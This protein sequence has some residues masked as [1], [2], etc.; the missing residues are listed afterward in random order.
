V[1]AA[2][3]LGASSPVS[4][5]L[6]DESGGLWVATQDGLWWRGEGPGRPLL[7]AS[8]GLG[9]A[10][11]RVHRLARAGE[12]LAVATDAGVFVAWHGVGWQRVSAAG[13]PVKVLALEC[14]PG[15]CGLWWFDGGRLWRAA[16][17]LRGVERG[18][19][20]LRVDEVVQ[21]AILGAPTAGSPVDLVLGSPLGDVIAVYGRALAV[22]SWR[23]VSAASRSGGSPSPTPS[24]GQAPEAVW[25]GWTIW[26]P[27]MPPGAMSRRLFFTLGE[28]WL[29]TDRGLLRAVDPRAGWA[30]AAPPAGSS[31]IA[32]LAQG[33]SEVWAATGR[34][35][36][37]GSTAA[38]P[39]ER[40]GDA[41]EV[42]VSRR[43]RAPGAPV[44]PTIQELHRLALQHLG[45]DPRRARD[46]RRRAAQRSW[47]P[48]VELGFGYG[49]ER[50]R[51]RDRD[52][53]YSSGATRQLFDRDR[54]RGHDWDAG[55]ELRWD[56]AAAIFDPELIDLA[57][58]HRAQ[59]ALRDDVLDEVTQLYFERLRVLGSLA[60]LRGSGGARGLAE[61]RSEARRL[62]E[63]AEEL[64]AGLDAW[65]G[66]AFSHPKE[67]HPW[68]PDRSE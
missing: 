46:L 10:A 5:L 56:L 29:A 12:V 35:V 36:L 67:T 28:Y 37:R 8:P 13:N 4:D 54:S 47:W 57:R 38:D 59:I 51:R 16:L 55:L 33:G 30:R 23:A 21:H 22:R 9:E 42:Q 17:R 27:V 18:G 41:G 48:E 52:Q 15:R 19:F 61:T 2:V 26:R 65:T 43:S 40:P 45:L 32:G 1:D 62:R 7:D 44:E 14:G 34:G 39:V 25:P 3:A 20:A 58:E 53:T 11:R 6:Y 60:A 50:T 24:R 64:A 63:R 49:G 68:V 31:A 66:G